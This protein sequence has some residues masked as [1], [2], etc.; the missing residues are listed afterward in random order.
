MTI[1]IW[2]TKDLKDDSMWIH[3]KKPYLDDDG[4]WI[5]NNRTCYIVPNLKQG[6][7]KRIILDLED[8]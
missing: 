7:K 1:T 8:M 6:T 5:S 2:V 4:I 3:S